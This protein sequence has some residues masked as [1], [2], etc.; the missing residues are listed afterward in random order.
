MIALP[1]RPNGNSG[2]CNLSANFF[3]AIHR[4][5]DFR[6]QMLEV[7]EGCALAREYF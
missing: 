1:V 5:A 6:C 2:Y 7:S 3:L 4:K